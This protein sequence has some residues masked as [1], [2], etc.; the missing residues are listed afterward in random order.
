MSEHRRLYIGLFTGAALP[1]LWRYP[2]ADPTGYLRM[3]HWLSAARK[4]E[5]A[6]VHF[7]F[8]ADDLGFPLTPRGMHPKA[9]EL[10][11]HFPKA[12]PL[13]IIPAMAAVTRELGLVVTLPTMSERPQVMARRLATLDH[14]T[15]GRLGWNVVTGAGQNASARLLGEEL[16]PHDERYA[17]ADEFVDYAVTLW[18]DSWDDDAL[19]V[20]PAAGVYARPGAVHEVVYQGEHYR[21]AGPLAV[22]PSPQRTPVIFQAGASAAGQDLAA[23]RAEAVFLASEPDALKAQI[24]G[25]RRRAVAAGRDP[26]SVRCLI[27]G[28]FTV[29]PTA[30]EARETR[31]RLDGMHSIEAAAVNF[32]FFTGIDLLAFDLDSPLPDITTETGRTNLERYQP[33]DGGPAPTVRQILEEFQRNGVMGKPFVG[34]PADVVDQ[35]MAMA[36]YT[37]ADGLLVQTGPTGTHDDFLDLVMPELHER[38]LVHARTPGHTLRQQLFGPHAT[39][40]PHHRAD[41]GRSRTVA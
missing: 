12:D 14:L 36:E 15:G 27:S 41:P 28:T 22:P 20:D 29:A 38:G 17:R 1:P 35:A 25:I 34:T 4:S 13:P 10:G 30:E 24:A 16:V 19:V 3:D 26:R 6:G 9:A 5:A 2:G 39:R 18:E 40:Y 11:I 31:T 21:G 32:S 23:R 8:L 37:D 33:K 7:L